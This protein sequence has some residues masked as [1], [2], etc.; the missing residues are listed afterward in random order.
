MNQHFT[1]KEENMIMT[2]MHGKVA[3]LEIMPSGK[4]IFLSVPVIRAISQELERL[5]RDP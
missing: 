2:S 4:L 1:A 3:L 5:E